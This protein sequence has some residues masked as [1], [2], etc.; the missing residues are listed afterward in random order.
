MA[1]TGNFRR[2]LSADIYDICT[3]REG[4][5]VIPRIR[6]QTELGFTKGGKGWLTTQTFCER[7]MWKPPLSINLTDWL[8]LA[9]AEWKEREREREREGES[10]LHISMTFPWEKTALRKRRPQWNNVHHQAVLS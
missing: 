3:E 7:P 2:A 5:Q 4:G 9:K 8:R 6:K 1:A 10:G